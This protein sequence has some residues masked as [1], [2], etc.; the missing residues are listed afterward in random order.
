ML[1]LLGTPRFSLDDA[2]FELKRRKVLALF[3][4]LAITGQPH[5]RAVLTDLLYPKQSRDRSMSDFRQTLSFLKN[6]IGENWLSSDRRSVSLANA[7][8]V[9]I[10]VHEFCRLVR[11]SR[12][13]LQDGS[14]EKALYLFNNAARLYRGEFLSGFYLRDSLDFEEWQLSQ[15]ENL[16]QHYAYVL[17]QLVKIHSM[18]K[19]YKTAIDYGNRWLSLDP[20][21]QEVHRHLM[22]LYKLDGQHAAAT[23]QYEIC[24]N[25]LREELQEPPDEETCR[26]REAISSPDFKPGPRFWLDKWHQAQAIYP[27]PHNHEKESKP[28]VAEN[29]PSG[30][31][32]FLSIDFRGFAQRLKNHPQPIEFHPTDYK[33]V[34]RSSVELGGGQIIGTENNTP[35]A[36]FS[37]ASTAIR[38]AKDTQVLCQQELLSMADAPR[39][40]IPIGPRVVLHAG[41]VERQQEIYIGSVIDRIAHLLEAANE[42][43][44][45]LSSPMVELA[46]DALPEGA[47]LR[48]L[49]PHRLRDLSPPKP[50]YQL[51]HPELLADFPALKSLE[52]RPNNLP[53]QLT[54]L[55]G[56]RKELVELTNFFRYEEA[57]ILTLTGPGGTGKTRLALQVAAQQIDLFEH[58]VYFVG[59]A[60]IRK[61][62]GVLP[63]I[64]Q[65]LDVRETMR[66]DRSLMEV[67]KEYLRS[68]RILLVLDNFEH[69]ASASDQ[70]VELLA[71]STGLKVLVTSRESLHLKGEREF[72]VSPLSIPERD[73]GEAVERLSQY[74]AVRLFIERAVAVKS[75]FS[76]TDENAPVIAEICV[77][78]DGLPLAI[79]LAASKLK[80]LSAKDL[81][82]RLSNRLKLLKGGSRDLPARQQTLRSTIDWSYKLLSE[83]E[84]RLFERLS[85]FI[86]GC[87]LDAAEQVCTDAEGGMGLDVLDGLVS[88]VDKSLLR[89]DEVA[90]ETRFGML[91]TIR[92]YSQAKLEES[93]EA[94]K[95]R[96]HHAQYFLRLAEEAEPMLHSREQMLWLD[97]LERENNNLQAAMGWLLKN[98]KAQE[99]LRLGAALY[100]FWY[101]YGHINDGEKWLNQA[102]KLAG[103]AEPS[104]IR[105]KALHALGWLVY[106]QSEWPRA[107]DLHEQSLA[108]FR[109]LDDRQGEASALS[110]LGVVERWLNEMEIGRQYSEEAVRIA[111]EVGDPHLISVSLV[112]AYATTDGK[113]VGEPPLAELEEAV[114]LSRNGGDLWN[115]ASAIHGLGDLFRELGQHEQALPRYEEALRGFR[116]LKDRWMIAW[117]LEGMGRNSFLD[118][119]N[120]NAEKYLAESISH[121]SMLGDKR[122]TMFTLSIL[123]MVVRAEEKH[124]RAACLLGAY[125][126]INEALIG[127]E[128]AGCEMYSPELLTAFGEYQRDFA[129]EWTLGS[130]MSFEQAIEYAV[131]DS[132]D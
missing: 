40:L 44:I 130:H 1:Y 110:E 12:R 13:L 64:A 96:Q 19:E 7:G 30:V 113:F 115:M 52:S 131:E 51:M 55:V 21:D 29:L 18:R 67:L 2:A 109:E 75:D 28:T 91:E 81:M 128:A 22:R 33:A 104:G 99:A 123:A 121:F 43:Q 23:R 94:D 97:R 78:L 17:E 65:A 82:K 36:V 125:K 4:Y 69:V 100:W 80:V 35:C 118:G 54:S 41:K 25:T 129:S 20:L 84:R 53:S 6:T 79:E 72:P 119:D 24:R 103:E 93:S 49:G 85:V 87:S 66:R 101:R 14:G 34:F 89:R 37:D 83:A 61:P 71:A 76:V 68:R 45:L 114:E 11:E 120:R 86:G 31:A 111:R 132:N 26:L 92:E 3:V 112:W 38:V 57:Q 124:P 32:A 117:T 9:W 88:L 105:A 122:D 48:S 39:P 46:N 63:S 15:Q 59:L 102:L 73:I 8:G 62:E 27:A 95:A 74:E 42:G 56:R 108:L 127:S 90:G 126:S 77:H 98:G 5:S 106:I 107:R 50:I 58:G 60:T 47:S 10:D 16:Q 116:Q 70:V